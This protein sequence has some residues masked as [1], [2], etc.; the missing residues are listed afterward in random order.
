[1]SK[2][3]VAIQ[4][5]GRLSEKSIE[6]L[7]GC[8]ISLNN[9]ARKLKIEAN[10]FPLELLFLRDDD[11]P[12]YV[13]QGVAD[14]GILGQNELLEQDKNV[15]E[16]LPLGFA[17]CRMSLA[18]PRGSEYNNIQYF[19]GKRIT[20]S[21]PNILSK[22]LK[23]Q[24]V[25]AN[26]DEVSGSVEIAPGIGLAD[27]IFDIV[28]SGSTLLMNGLLEVEQ[29]L[30]SEATVIMTRNVTPTIRAIADQLLFRMRSVLAAKNNKYI[31]MN[32]PNES[33]DA[34]SEL[35]PGMKCP[36]IIPLPD[37][38]WSSVQ[39]VVREDQFWEV[40]EELKQ[41]GAEG[42]LVTP[43]EKMIL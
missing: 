13:E 9:G 19:E 37:Q 5:S 21:Y 27:G 36:T 10:N 26:I 8:G 18:V 41:L 11:I 35:L 14:M 16:I 43:I 1:M 12:Q 31:L 30:K 42:I 28:S 22:Y 24:G 20:T 39:S 34:I 15:E 32:A 7:K 3:K 38:G 23:E 2:L 25:N 6:L 33:L 4:K 29:V 17:K 40:I